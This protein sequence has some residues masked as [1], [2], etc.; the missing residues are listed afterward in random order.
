MTRNRL[1]SPIVPNKPEALCTRMWIG[2][3]AIKSKNTTIE[4][5]ENVFMCFKELT[6]SSRNIK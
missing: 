1:Q 2:N 3:V 6:K 4:T 5:I